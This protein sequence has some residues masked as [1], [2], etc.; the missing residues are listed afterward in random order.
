MSGAEHPRLLCCLRAMLIAPSRNGGE[1]PSKR[2]CSEVFN[3]TA[4]KNPESDLGFSDLNVNVLE[5]AITEWQLTVEET[6]VS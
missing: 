2:G 4:E 3:L 6:E 5:A 1:C